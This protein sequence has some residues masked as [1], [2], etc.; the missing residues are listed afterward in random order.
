MKLPLSNHLYNDFLK[1]IQSEKGKCEQQATEQIARAKSQG[2]KFEEKFASEGIVK[3]FLEDVK[4]LKD[5]QLLE[6]IGKIHDD[7]ERYIE[8][9]VKEMDTAKTY[10][11]VSNI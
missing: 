7:L 9:T 1:M 5:H 6:D 10:G 8:D 3:Q 2:L 4:F 11:E